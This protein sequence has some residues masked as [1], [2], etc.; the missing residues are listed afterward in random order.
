MSMGQPASPRRASVQVVVPARNEEAAIG[1][2]LVSLTSQQGIDFQVT[3]V[4]DG[5]T[6][7]TR[8]IAESFPGVRVIGA[9]EPPP[10]VSGKCNAL[11]QGAQ[12]ATAEWLL[13]TD[14][15]T[16]HYPGSLE[17]AVREAEARSADLFSLSPE[18][19]AVS[20]AEQALLPV[21]FADL[22]RTYPPQRVND[23]A[24]PV[25][26]AN[27]QYLLARREV[28]E[29]LGGHRA[30]ADKILEDVELARLFKA[31]H[32]KLWF[33]HGAGMVRTR[34]YR[35]FRSMVEGWTKNL[36]LLFPHPVLLAAIRALEF[37][38]IS[39]LTV[40]AISLLMRDDFLTGSTATI[41]GSLLAI[42]VARRF[43]RAHFPARANLMAFFGLPLFAGLL[44]RSWLHS[45]VLGAVTWK[46]RTYS[47]PVTGRASGSSILKSSGAKS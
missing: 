24:D 45:K 21:I 12:G 41:V 4:D 2:C 37:L 18:Q 7:R 23:P 3:V 34:M 36:V 31:S 11:I 14:A 33:R 46:G 30:I 8:A 27:G 43:L 13:F 10:G 25:V 29:S 40:S 42:S 20:W 26:A 22:A 5:S 17:A 9:T 15:D 19:E 38:A 35:D 16:Y 47:I 1:R 32:H 44:V 28:Y 39:L 6:D